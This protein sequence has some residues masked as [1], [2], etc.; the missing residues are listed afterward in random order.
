MRMDIREDAFDFFGIL[1]QCLN[2]GREQVLE[3][4]ELATDRADIRLPTCLGRDGIDGCWVER[5]QAREI[6]TLIRQT[7]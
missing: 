4:L 1:N 2:R 7:Q 6:T 3:A 5:K